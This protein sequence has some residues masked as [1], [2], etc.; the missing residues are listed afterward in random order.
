MAHSKSARK[1]IRQN[2]TRRLRNRTYMSALRTQIKKM[3]QALEAR[4]RGR[5]QAEYQATTRALDKAVTKGVIRS[6]NASRH[7]S[8]LA[9][10]LAKLAQTS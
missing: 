8:R 6:N 4:D 5:A 3:R 10:E 9:R 7:K 1:R 2:E